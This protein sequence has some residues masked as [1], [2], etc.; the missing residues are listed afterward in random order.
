MYYHFCLFHYVFLSVEKLVILPLHV[1]YIIEVR[2][3]Y[4]EVF[5]WWCP[6]D[7]RWISGRASMEACDFSVIA[8]WLSLDL[9][10]GV[11]IFCSC[12]PYFWCMFPL[13]CFWV[14]ASCHYCF[15]CVYHFNVV[16]VFRVMRN[17]LA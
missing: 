7:M 13:D 14:T 5:L 4:P 2:G 16:H 10:V 9:L 12:A 17:S 11:S 8:S 3:I 1:Q 15:F 6:R